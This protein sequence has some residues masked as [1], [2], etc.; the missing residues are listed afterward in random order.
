M[1]CPSGPECRWVPYHDAPSFEGCS[2]CG[3]ERQVYK[4]PEGVMRA[5][6]AIAEVEVE[7]ACPNDVNGP[8]IGAER[9]DGAA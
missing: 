7:P 8:Q 4:P 2:T 5:P 1:T 3:I 9:M 6:V